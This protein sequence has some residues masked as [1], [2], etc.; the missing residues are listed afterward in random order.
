MNVNKIVLL[1]FVFLLLISPVL[2]AQAND[3]EFSLVIFG[4]TRVAFQGAPIP[5][6][7]ERIL[8]ETDLI[9][10]DLV[11]HTGDLVWGYGDSESQLQYSEI[12]PMVVMGKANEKTERVYA[13]CEEG[14]SS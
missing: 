10:P 12:A 3:D 4:D 2:C 11:V 1:I 14:I 7:F 8:T 9:N 6:A 13:T 5:V